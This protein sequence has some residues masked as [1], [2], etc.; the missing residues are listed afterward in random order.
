MNTHTRLSPI[1][2][3]LLT[4]I[5]TAA[6]T[7]MASADPVMLDVNVPRRIS[8]GVRGAVE[9]WF[10]SEI[11]S[12][13]QLQVS[14]DLVRWDSEG[15]S[16]KG[17][18]GEVH[19]YAGTRN[20][21]SAFF[22]VTD[23]GDPDNTAPVGPAGPQG[24]QGLTGS[25]GP[26]GP[27]GSTGEQGPPGPPGTTD[28]VD[29]TSPQIIGGTKRFTSF[30]ETPSAL[31]AADYQVANKKYVDATASASSVVTAAGTP[32]MRSLPDRFA[33]VINARSLSD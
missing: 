28:C 33:D 18:G 16:I 17:T 21:P 10:Q 7:L 9:V 3:L 11:G 23:D 8:G 12:Y 27:R 5:I 25:P 32:T 4:V 31:P 26:Q 1:C 14:I 19:T 15:Y 22:R 30:L 6:P 24:P 29:L 2:L 13:Y 20:L